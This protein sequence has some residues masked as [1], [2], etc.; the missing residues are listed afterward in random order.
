MTQKTPSQISFLPIIGGWYMS[1]KVEGF[2]VRQ[3]TTKDTVFLAQKQPTRQRKI[4]V[5]VVI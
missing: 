3:K 4:V 2:N 5:V 1:N